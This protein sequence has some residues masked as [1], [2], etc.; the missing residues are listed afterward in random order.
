MDDSFVNFLAKY[1]TELRYIGIAIN[2]ILFLKGWGFI[3]IWKQER[4]FCLSLVKRYIHNG[5]WGII[6]RKNGLK[7]A[8]LSGRATHLRGK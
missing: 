6:Q 1:N 8:A 4:G 7:M 2:I 3:D 5:D